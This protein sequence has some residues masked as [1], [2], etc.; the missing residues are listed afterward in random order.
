MENEESEDE[1]SE[2]DVSVETEELSEDDWDVFELDEAE[3]LA[4]PL[5]KSSTA[6][7]KEAFTDHL[8]RMFHEIDHHHR[9]H[10]HH[11]SLLFSVPSELGILKIM[12]VMRTQG[13]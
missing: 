6:E 5:V 3:E 13:R 9:H 7:D 2:S 11:G 4:E 1:Q 10:H 12:A 8:N